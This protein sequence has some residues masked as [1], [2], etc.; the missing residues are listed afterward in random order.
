MTSIMANTISEVAWDPGAIARILRP[1]TA[2][3]NWGRDRF[4]LICPR[5]V[6]V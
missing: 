1:V 2:V 3:D 6:H 5:V 4:M